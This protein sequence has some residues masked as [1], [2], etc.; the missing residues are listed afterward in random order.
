MYRLTT[1]LN[2]QHT[3]VGLVDEINFLNDEDISVIKQVVINNNL[4]KGFTINNPLSITYD[5]SKLHR[6]NYLAWIKYD[7]NN[8]QLCNLFKKIYN[9]IIEVNKNHFQ[10]ILTDVEP[11]QYTSY[12]KG[13][14]YNKHLDIGNNLSLGNTHRKLSFS[15][16]LSNPN[17]YEGGDLCVYDSDECLIAEKSKG[18][19]TFFPSFMLHEVKEVAKGKRLS[20]VGW[21]WGPKFV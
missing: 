4:S 15:I 16:Q 10:F 14:Y 1:N 2:K 21:A 20:L 17:E 11:F 19:I 5:N 12:S 18:S 13:E 7:E 8:A 3:C 9:K 6:N